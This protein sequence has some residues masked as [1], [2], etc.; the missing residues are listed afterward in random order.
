M[1]ERVEAQ[2]FVIVRYWQ[3]TKL[4]RLFAAAE[5]EE[6]EDRKQQIEQKSS[7]GSDKAQLA[8]EAPP[9]YS[10]STALIKLP[11]ISLGELDTTLNR[12][13]ESPKDMLRVS[14]SVIDPLLNRW[15]RWY[16]VREQLAAQLNSRS[17]PFV[18]NT[19]ES[20]GGPSESNGDVHEREETRRGHYLE[21]TTTDWRK[22]HSVAA[23]QEAAKL[24]KKYASLQPSI[25]VEGSDG[26]DDHGHQPPKKAA[27]SRHVIDSSSETSD[28]EPEI[29]RQRR[30][31]NAEASYDKRPRHPPQQSNLSHSYGHSGDA[32]ASFGGRH[33]SSSNGTPQSTPRS[34]LSAPRS[35]GAHRPMT[36]PVQNQY[37]HAYTTPA[38]IHTAIPPNQYTP[39]SP[40]T[41]HST[42]PNAS[43][44]PPNYPGY[45][46]S[47]QAYPQRYMPAPG[48]R[49]ATQMA[50]QRPRSREGNAP[51]SPSRHSG[52]SAHS[53][54]RSN[55][56]TRRAERNRKHKN[57]TKGAAKGVFGAGALA[58]FLDALEGLE[59]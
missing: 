42:I 23:T 26:E 19:Y 55:E 21:G 9:D 4:D 22:P 41:P 24:R 32:H 11:N 5:R 3:N 48:Y 30:K 53:S 29:V 20:S 58:G 27:P 13:R 10:T 34:P 33:H 35:P 31:S 50:P 36:S 56:E 38:P 43:L 2:N 17:R 57:M 49:L 18:H 54:Q 37:H 16:E 6:D 15:T 44:Y 47:P 14:E 8:I 40:Y 59:V 28:S 51:R 25:S 45:N 39:H 1:Q 12:I 46:P 7:S 52:H